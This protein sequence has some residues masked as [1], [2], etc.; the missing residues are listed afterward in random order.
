MFRTIYTASQGWYNRS[1][2]WFQHSK[3]P[4]ITTLRWIWWGTIG[5]WAMVLFSGINA[6]FLQPFPGASI[7]GSVAALFVH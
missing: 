7:V 3:N 1:T 4:V 2:D 6:D 5:L